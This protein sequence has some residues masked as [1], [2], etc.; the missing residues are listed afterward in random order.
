M[1]RNKRSHLAYRDSFFAGRVGIR[2]KIY[3]YL[4]VLTGFMLSLVWISQSA[5]LFNIFQRSAAGQV[6]NSAR[7]LKAR[8]AESKAMESTE[9]ADAIDQ[10]G[11]ENDLGIMVLDKNG[12][13][14]MTAG[15]LWYTPFAI[16]SL[17]ESREWVSKVPENGKPYIG[18]V[19]YTFEQ[20][21]A[22]AGDDRD[23]KHDREE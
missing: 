8:I 3:I 15:R 23:G 18:N 20:D 21:M 4:L 1:K 13:P 14:I 7:Q 17:E 9:L 19:K 6:N 10:M 22:V 5:L 11:T 12:E 2:G 16:L